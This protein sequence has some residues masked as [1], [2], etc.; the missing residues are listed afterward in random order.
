MGWTPHLSAVTPSFGVFFDFLGLK[1]YAETT[2]SF[3]HTETKFI[4]I[5]SNIQNSYKVIQTYR[6]SQIPLSVIINPSIL[7][8]WMHSNISY[9]ENYRDCLKVSAGAYCFQIQSKVLFNFLSVIL[10]IFGIFLFQLG[11]SY[12]YIQG[13]LLFWVIL[14]SIWRNCSEKKKS[15]LKRNLHHLASEF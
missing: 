2:N 10:H 5:H 15:K 9:V 8:K 11:N 13:M 12:F 7:V 4:Q 6:N 1:C 3:K 14:V